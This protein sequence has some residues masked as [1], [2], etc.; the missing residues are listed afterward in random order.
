PQPNDPTV[1]E[2]TQRPG[3]SLTKRATGEG[4]YAVND[5][6]NYEIVVRNKGNVTLTDVVVTD[7][8]AEIVSGSQIAS[9]APNATATVIARHQI[10]QADIDAGIVMNQAK[11]TGDDP[12]GK[13]TP[14]A[15][16][17]NP[18][19]PQPNDPTVVELTQQPGLVLT[20]RTTS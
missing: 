20:K 4:P 10:T 11:V 14:E 19:T 1:V 8:N 9:L 12:E 5:Y 18:D 17:D 15:S 7:D 2:L 13:P 3:L 16:S 6:I